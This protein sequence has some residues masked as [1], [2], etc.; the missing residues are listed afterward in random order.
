MISRLLRSLSFILLCRTAIVPRRAAI[1]PCRAR[2]APPQSKLQTSNQRIALELGRLPGTCMFHILVFCCILLLSFP[3][4]AAV[5]LLSSASS[6]HKPKKLQST[7]IFEII[8][9][10]VKLR[11][12]TPLWLNKV[13][14]Q[15]IFITIRFPSSRMNY[16]FQL[17]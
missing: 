16:L 6:L 1:V 7:K 11:T 8:T 12:H 9:T 15:P 13:L 17:I 4:T 5:I 3:P 10:P 14:N 2:A